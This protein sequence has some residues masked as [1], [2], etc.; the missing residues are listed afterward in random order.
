MRDLLGLARLERRIRRNRAGRQLLRLIDSLDR[1]GAALGAGAMAF[2]AFLSLVPLVAFLGYVT[3]RLHENGDLLI[4]PFERAAPGP[5][6]DFVRNDLS[7]LADGSTFAIAPVSFVAFVWT[8][9]AG[10]ST[11]MSVFETMFH[12]PPRPWVVRRAIAAGCVLGSIVLLGG[13]TVAA[14]ALGSLGGAPVHRLL[15]F[16]LPPVVIVGMTAAFFRIAIRGPRPRA[17]RRIFPGAV[18]TLLLW[19]VVSGLFSLYVAQFSRYV[20]LYGSLATAAIFLFWLWLLA[21]LLLV[22]GEINAMLEGI[23]EP[24]PEKDG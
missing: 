11:A 6:G 20:T 10:I 19:T 14:L 12:S 21:L 16:A 15:A 22:G 7:R 9:S 18:A 13:L 24:P 5:V 17:R 8:S 1:H 2:D 4:G 23:R 3:A